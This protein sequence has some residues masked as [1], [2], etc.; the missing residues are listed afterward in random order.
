VCDLNY[1]TLYKGEYPEGTKGCLGQRGG[2]RGG[3]GRGEIRAKHR[4]L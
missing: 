4:G 2:G 3:E 1:V